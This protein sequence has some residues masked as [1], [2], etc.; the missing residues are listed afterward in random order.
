MLILIGQ[1]PGY[2]RVPRKVELDDRYEI[3]VAKRRQLTDNE[4]N[5]YKG[6]VVNGLRNGYGTLTYAKTQDVY[7]GDFENDVPHGTGKYVRAGGGRDGTFEG[8]WVDG[9]V[10]Q[11]KKGRAKIKEENGDIYEGGFHHWKRHGKGV[12]KTANGEVYKGQFVDG[13]PNGQGAIRYKNGETYEGHFKD[14]KCLFCLGTY[15]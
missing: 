8:L 13:L 12:L 2:V 15:N 9:E 5:L 4:G 7:Q 14:G 6:E 11:V 3:M 1:L 10:Q